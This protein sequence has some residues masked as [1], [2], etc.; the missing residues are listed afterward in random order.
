MEQENVTGDVEMDF[1]GCIEASQGIGSLEPSVDD[2]IS[3]LLLAEMGSSGKTRKRDGRKGFRRLVS[4]IYSP[5]AC[6]GLV[7]QD[8]VET[9]YGGV[10]LGSHRLG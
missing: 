3:Q 5:P 6:Y 10:R 8:Q 2:C 7:E 4:E 9:S 1:V